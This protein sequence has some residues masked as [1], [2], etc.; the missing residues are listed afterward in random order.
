MSGMSSILGIPPCRVQLLPQRAGIEGEQ[1]KGESSVP[2]G[3][4]LLHF[5]SLGEKA[6]R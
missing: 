5:A 4:P 6:S 2:S 1:L 3:S